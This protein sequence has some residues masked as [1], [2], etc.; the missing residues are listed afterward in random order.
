MRVLGIDQSYTSCG[1]VIL[2]D[3]KYLTSARFNSID[4][5]DKPARAWQIA[6]Q[7]LALTRQ[8]KPDKIAIE[9][10]A[11]GMRGSATRD[12]AG[13]Q[14]I[15]ICLL[16]YQGDVDDVLIVSP[17]TVKKFGAGSGKATK[18]QLIESLPDDVMKIFTEKLKYKK[19][20]GLKDVTDAYWIARVAGQPKFLTQTK[21]QK[22]VITVTSKDKRD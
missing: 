11:F 17:L 20:T 6:E 14:F 3:D 15:I 5:L 22:D 12:L 1:C 8:Y 16:R 13:L 4:T 18:E 19:T 2:D 10:L 21:K 7:V 9:G